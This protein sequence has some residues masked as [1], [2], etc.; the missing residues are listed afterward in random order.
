MW[1]DQK[2]RNT[3]P[4]L[5]ISLINLLYT[6]SDYHCRAGASLCRLQGCCSLPFASEIHDFWFHT[7][8]LFLL[9]QLLCFRGTLVLC[10]CI[11]NNSNSNYNVNIIITN[12]YFH[13]GKE[14]YHDTFTCK[15]ILCIYPKQ[16]KPLY[17]IYQKEK[18]SGSTWFPNLIQHC[19]WDWE[20]QLVLLSAYGKQQPHRGILSEY[21]HSWQYVLFLPSLLH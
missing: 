8:N 7:L 9:H 21:L 17:I 5:P 11:L 10:D 14:F 4:H 1:L 2:T 19:L 3:K 12:S 16:C 18:K 13:I 15:I 20:H 6:F